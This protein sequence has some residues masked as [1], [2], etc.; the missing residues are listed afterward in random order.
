M[1]GYA[2]GETPAGD[3]KNQNGSF[4]WIQTKWYQL[5]GNNRL[6][7]GNIHRSN[8]LGQPMGAI[9]CLTTL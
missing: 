7:S 6:V 2:V 9:G 3:A 1:C 5:H 4:A 8:F